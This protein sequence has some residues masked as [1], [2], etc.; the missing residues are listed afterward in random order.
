MATPA[1]KVTSIHEVKS[2]HPLDIP[3][4][5]VLGAFDQLGNPP[6][7]I[8]VV[9]IYKATSAAAVPLPRLQRAISRLL[10]YYPHLT[11]RLR[12]SPDDGLR[13]IDRLGTGM[14]LLEATCDAP[15][16]AFA[17]TSSGH[18]GIDVF[19]LPGAGDLLLAPWDPSTEGTQN[20]PVFTIQ[21]TQFSCSAVAIGMRMSHVVCDAGS[22][23]QLYQHLAE[24]YRGLGSDACGEVKLSKPP[25]F[26]PLMVDKVL[27][28]DEEERERAL[29][30]VPEFFSLVKPDDPGVQWS[31]GAMTDPVIGRSM[32]FSA[33][34]LSGLKARA[35]PPD[36]SRVSTFSALSAYLWQRT[37]LARL[38]CEK[39][40]LAQEPSPHSKAAFLTSVEFSSH[41]GL[42]ENFFGNTIVTPF[43]EVASDELAAVPL[44][45]IAK[46]V[47]KVV[48]SVNKDDVYKVGTWVAAQPDKN[49]IRFEFP[50]TQ[51]TFITSGWHRFPLYEGATLDVAPVFASPTFIATALVDGLVYLLQPKEKD[52]GIDIIYSLKSSTWKYLNITEEL[53][54][55]CT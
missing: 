43:V 30:D 38:E 52:G 41:L 50:Y 1:V 25:H 17:K 37:H 36:G 26:P 48:R 27:H 13:T 9:W 39:A 28:M 35:T 16:E 32:R 2:A 51:S 54:R 31:A 47:D 12:I 3:D 33:A 15:L 8:N 20:N 55:A 22:F 11:G 14:H 23:L 21:R 18:D 49:A 42:T 40:G 19:D 10:D 53:K 4:P 29:V 34:G 24:I 6:I 5:Y 46:T 45:K 7:S 44:W